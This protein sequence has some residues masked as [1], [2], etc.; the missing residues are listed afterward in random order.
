[1]AY[2]L[3]VFLELAKLDQ[4]L[5]K[6]KNVIGV[7]SH[8]ID[9]NKISKK[10]E[11]ILNIDCNLINRKIKK[12]LTLNSKSNDDGYY[13]LNKEI[14]RYLL[15]QIGFKTYEDADINDFSDYKVNLN[16]NIPENLKNK[17]GIVINSGTSNYATNI[18]RAYENSMKLCDIDGYVVNF[19]EPINFNRFPL[20]A[21]PNFLI[22]IFCSNGFKVNKAQLINNDESGSLVS[23]LKMFYDHKEFYLIQYFGFFQF[24]KHIFYEFC[25]FF[26][27]RKNINYIDPLDYHKIK[28]KSFKNFSKKILINN[29]FGIKNFLKKIFTKLIRPF[30]NKHNKSGRVIVYLLF[31]KIEMSDTAQKRYNE[32][33]LHYEVQ[34]NL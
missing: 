28:D 25:T 2:P 31:Q 14:I 22:D 23:D 32:S 33:S 17:F 8:N 3:K 1:M 24:L 27:G 30:Y 21:S 4:K 26:F 7:G 20:G 11:K 19:C 29:T 15:T 13:T 6:N 18:I 16:E 5:I 9:F 10:Y 12:L 34:Y